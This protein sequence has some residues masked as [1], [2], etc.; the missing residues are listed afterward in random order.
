MHMKVMAKHILLGN[1][2]LA[3]FGVAQTGAPAAKPVPAAKPAAAAKSIPTEK[4]FATP[5]AA[6]EALKAAAA[7]N[8]QAA[9]NAVFGPDRQK[10][11]SGDPVE[12]RNALTHFATVLAQSAKLEKHG[13]TKYTLLTGDDNWPFPVPIVKWGDQWRFD[14]A[15]GVEEI[16]N[17]RIGENELSAIATCRAYVL[18]QW[19][20]YTSAVDTARD[21]VAVYAQKVISTPGQH[22]GLYWATPSGAP[23]SPLGA[24]VAEARSEGYAAG[25]SSGASRTQ[26]Q[27]TPFHGYFFKILTR[28]GPHAPGGRYNYIINGNMIGGYALIAYPDKWGSSGVM[29]FIVNQQGR[30][31]EKNL[32][33]HTAEI[34]APITEYNPDPSWKLVRE[35]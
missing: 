7:A 6:V 15:A 16:L 19:E 26:G 12:D 17:R 30:V 13:D 35:P 18:A 9:L 5:E 29:T 28:Q 3:S 33:A 27:H 10:L 1:F 25:G 24:L 21:G 14:T 2:L 4:L 20:Y 31:Y 22:D 11:L 34:A 23:P 32:G 8:D